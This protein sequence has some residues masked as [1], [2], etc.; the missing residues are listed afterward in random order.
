MNTFLKKIYQKPEKGS[1]MGD[2]PMLEQM[3]EI[4][5]EAYPLTELNCGDYACQKL[6]GMTFRIRAFQARGLGHVSIMQASGFF[7]LMVM[8]TLI[9]NPTQLEMPL[10]SYDRVLAM[11]NDT[12]IFEIYDTL[13]AL[14]DLSALAAVQT[15]YEGLPAHDLGQHW[16]DSVK[17][18]VS[19]SKKGKKARHTSAFDACAL[20][21]LTAYLEAAGSASVCDPSAKCRKAAVYVEGLLTHGGPSTD[22][23]LKALGREKTEK[24]FRTILFGTEK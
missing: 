7:G 20:E 24:L 12:L 1:G 14:A 3:C 16:Y 18:P 10:L 23:F 19:L 2:E 21:Y 13:L 22:V 15:H 9:I 8:D 17:L 11:G 5:R 6:N 4:L